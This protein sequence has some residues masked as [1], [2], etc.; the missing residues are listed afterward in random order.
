MHRLTIHMIVFVSVSA[1][2]VFFWLLYG[3]SEAGLADIA[4][5]PTRARELG[6]WPVWVIA[7]WAT[8]LVIHG[9]ITATNAGRRVLAAE[10][11]PERRDLV[12]ESMR[13][14]AEVAGGLLDA[15]VER[16]TA[17]IAPDPDKAPSVT[18]GVGDSRWVAVMFTDIANST[19]LTEELGD[20]SWHKI[21]T[22]HRDVVRRC[23]DDHHGDEVA[24]QGDGFFIRHDGVGDAVACAVAIQ[25]TLGKRKNR[26]LPDLRIGI[27]A[28]EVVQDHD[29]DLM[30]KVINVAA[31]VTDAAGPG[32]ILVTES[33]ADNAPPE[34][35]LV[36]GGLRELKGVA[37][38]R[39]VLRVDW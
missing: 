21:L 8:V 2:L 28:G 37:Q 30:G 25:K 19:S 3:G 7:P 18:T 32:E 35:T 26:D 12:E 10:P 22:R 38:P 13:K 39:H 29:G 15:V 4:S 16:G 23:I 11:E 6:F 36:D 20:T 14:T 34:V 33:V 24:T 31:R 27:H 5:E 1:C 17:A 9:G